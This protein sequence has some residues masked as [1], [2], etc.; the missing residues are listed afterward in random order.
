VFIKFE[1]E[2]S[3]RVGG[4]E[5]GVF[6]FGK[7]FVKNEQKCCLYAGSQTPVPLSSLYYLRSASEM[8]V[9]LCVQSEL[10]RQYDST[11]AKP[12]GL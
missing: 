12:A 2:V 3:S 9:C 4:G 7:L 5:R 1:V 8:P 10:I 6:D 11:H